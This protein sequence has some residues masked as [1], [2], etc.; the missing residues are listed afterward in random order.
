[1][2]ARDKLGCSP[3]DEL[4]WSSRMLVA[5]APGWAGMVAPDVGC[6][7]PGMSWDGRPGSN[8]QLDGPIKIRHQISIRYQNFSIRPRAFWESNANDR[9]SKAIFDGSN[10]TF[11]IWFQI[12]PTKYWIWYLISI[13]SRFSES[14]QNVLNWIII[15]LQYFIAR[16]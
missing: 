13:W 11:E 12:W 3:R 2:L 4:G 16:G 1:M 8:P 14:F 7:R 6:L 5:F 10:T 15:W 9:G